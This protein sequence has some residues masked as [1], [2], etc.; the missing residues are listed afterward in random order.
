MSEIKLS[1]QLGAMAIIDS[2][3]AQRIALDEHLD[4]PKL[5]QKIT[6]RIRDYYQSSG[7]DIDDKL[8]EQG[9]KNWFS[10]RLRYQ[11]NKMSLSQRAAAFLYMTSKQ[12]LTGLAIILVALALA[13]KLSLYIGQHQLAALEKNIATQTSQSDQMAAQ[14]QTLSDQLSKM[15]HEPFIYAKVPADQIITQAENLLSNFQSRQAAP[16]VSA[17]NTPQRLDILTAVNQQNQ[18]LLTQ[19]RTLMLRW[20][21]LQKWDS[22]LGNMDKDPQLQ[23]YLKWAPDLTGKLAEATSALSNNA[24][25]TQIKIEAAFKA[26][27]RERMRDG[28]Y[29]TMDQR[30]QKLRNL[31][32]SRQDR[33]KVD[34]DISYARNLIARADLNDR[35]IPPLWLEALT[36]LDYTYDLIMQPLTLIIVDRVGEKSGVERTYDNSGGK[37]W[38]L[39]VETQ[40]PSH[41]PFP[42]SVKDSETGR[43][44]RTS[45]FGIRVSQKEYKKLKKDKLDDGHIDHALVGKKPAGQLGF[46]Y[47]RPVQDGVI[48]EW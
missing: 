42:I 20:P 44:T 15:K 40:T 21:L 41:T 5:R 16:L 32:L 13:W 4:L 24:A 11:T 19:V 10:Q 33:V 28:L 39:I 31:K 7:T 25:D 26:Y 1:D 46:T 17:E 27:D 30:T 38:Y 8:I 18:A 12:W 2:L 34:N 22:T 47:T 43:K 36:G 9:V 37:S 45:Q 14:A 48:T 23:T 6:Q 35:V 3:Y 29:F